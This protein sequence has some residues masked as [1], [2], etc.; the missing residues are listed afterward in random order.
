MTRENA[1]VAEVAP[2]EAHPDSRLLCFMADLR[3]APSGGQQGRHFIRHRELANQRVATET[4]RAAVPASPGG[5]ISLH[6]ERTA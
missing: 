3:E 1:E 5:D 2:R 4:V 6:P